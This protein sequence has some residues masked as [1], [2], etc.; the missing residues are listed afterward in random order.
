MDIGTSAYDKIG[1]CICYCYLHAEADSDRS[2]L[3]VTRRG[4]ENGGILLFGGIQ[5]LACRAISAS[6]ELLIKISASNPSSRK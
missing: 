4:M 6:S 5:R 3:A 1:R 2:V